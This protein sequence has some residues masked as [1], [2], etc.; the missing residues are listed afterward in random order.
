LV[1]VKS[2]LEPGI[3]V[4]SARMVGLKAG[5]SAVLKSSQAV[6][7]AASSAAKAG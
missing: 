7:A 4:V 6:P 5:A 2:G 1:E 3:Q